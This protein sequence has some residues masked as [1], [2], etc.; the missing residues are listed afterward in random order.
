MATMLPGDVLQN[1]C[2]AA[3]CFQC[4]IM[5]HIQGAA[6]YGLLGRGRGTCLPTTYPPVP[7]TVVPDKPRIQ[8]IL[9][10]CMLEAA[11]VTRCTSLP[12]PLTVVAQC[13]CMMGIQ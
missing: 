13:H 8:S 2:T 4:F 5:K 12:L 3:H 6:G 10:I 9:H 11:M 1:T 7:A